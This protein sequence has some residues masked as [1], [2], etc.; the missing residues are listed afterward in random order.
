MSSD[1]S[2]RPLSTLLTVVGC[3]VAYAVFFLLNHLM[4]NHLEF[5]RGVN[6]VFL[7]SGLR[8]SL[9]LV[10][11]E[12]GALGI[13]LSSICI[14]WFA[15]SLP[16]LHA[17]VI[18]SISGLAPWVAR[19]LCLNWLKM[20]PD[21]QHLNPGQL[22]QLA[23]IFAVISPVMHQLWFVWT[24]LNTDFLQGTLVMIV[25]DL[26]GTLLILFTLRLLI[27]WL[28]RPHVPV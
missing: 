11:L 4:F 15:Y 14:S 23:V 1:A 2:P 25:G 13:A 26:L 21:I 7:P 17:L 20:D 8:P 18:G 10:F 5:A 28:R 12:W 16:P 24:G 19:R 3:G 27:L 6:W 22:L 9:V